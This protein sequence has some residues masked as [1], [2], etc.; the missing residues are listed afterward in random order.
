MGVE[1]AEYA[2]TEFPATARG[3]IVDGAGHFL[4]LEK[5]NEVNDEILTFLKGS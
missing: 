1:V 4:H 3:R 5:P 2:M